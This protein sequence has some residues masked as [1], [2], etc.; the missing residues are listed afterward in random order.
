MKMPEKEDGNLAACVLL[1]ANP[2]E[3][4]HGSDDMCVCVCGCVF[5]EDKNAFVPVKRVFSM[6]AYSYEFQP[7]PEE[8]SE[9]SVR[10]CEWSEQA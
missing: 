1:N 5:T 4:W 9:M 2:Q 3:A 8:V 10:A 6:N 7:S